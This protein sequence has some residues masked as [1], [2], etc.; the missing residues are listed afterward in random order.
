MG[1]WMSQKASPTGGRAVPQ[2]CLTQLLVPPASA[3]ATP[4]ASVAPPASIQP[5][6]S[7][8]FSAVSWPVSTSVGFLP[9][10]FR[11]VSLFAPS[12]GSLFGSDPPTLSLPAYFNLLSSQSLL[13]KPSLPRSGASPAPP[14]PV[15][16]KRAFELGLQGPDPPINQPAALGQTSISTNQP[17]QEADTIGLGLG[18][19]RPR[20]NHQVGGAGHPGTR[21]SHAVGPEEPWRAWVIAGAGQV[22]GSDGAGVG[23]WNCFSLLLGEEDGDRAQVLGWG[24]SPGLGVD[25]SLRPLS[26]TSGIPRDRGARRA[27]LLPQAEWNGEMA[28][29]V[30]RK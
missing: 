29:L 6:V 22:I 14:S 25:R 2:D 26:K 21:D 5:C 20:L 30:L 12:L 17:G 9:L 19:I 28:H 18:V 11:M 24:T 23:G 1:V 10:F 27:H 8:S 16:E 4:L 3:R 7:F 15:H 13:L